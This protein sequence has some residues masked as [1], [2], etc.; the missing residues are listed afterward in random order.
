MLPNL[1][2][3]LKPTYII[4]KKKYKV[5]GQIGEGGFAFVYS[6]KSLEKTSK[7]TNYAV[8]RVLCQ[9]EEQLEEA[10]LE[11]KLLSTIRSN[12]ILPLLDSCRHVNKKD[13]TEVSQ[14]S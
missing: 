4:N 12:Y 1:P 8:K 6:V 9:T 2:S 5:N 11:I 13:Q 14:Y 7:N 3:L 10:N